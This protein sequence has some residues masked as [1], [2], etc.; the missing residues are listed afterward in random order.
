MSIW[1]RV[2]RTQARGQNVHARMPLREHLG[3]RVA[4]SGTSTGSAR[5]RL[6]GSARFRHVAKVLVVPPCADSYRNRRGVHA[7]LSRL[8]F[9]DGFQA[10]L[11]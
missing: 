6:T 3:A 1:V 9:V 10:G 4:D 2:R 11:R 7:L 5:S 8:L